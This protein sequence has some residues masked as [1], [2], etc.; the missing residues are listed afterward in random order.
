MKIEIQNL[1]AIKQ[2]EINLNKR[3]TVF[4]GPNNSG[5]TYAAFTIYALTKSG[6]KYFRSKSKNVL[7][8]ELIKNQTA[9]FEI[10]VE[11]IWNYRNEEL[12]SIKESLDS[13]YGIS[14]EIS[15]NLFKDFIP[16]LQ[17]EQQ[18]L[19]AGGSVIESVV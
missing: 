2:A 11:D 12:N 5:K 9:T 16:F 19:D 14:D 10:K 13:I 6:L 4:C 8:T 1:G 7:L 18:T 15:N 17:L 3:L